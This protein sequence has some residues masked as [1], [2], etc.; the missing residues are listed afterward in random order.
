ML[1]DDL[2]RTGLRGTPFSARMAEVLVKYLILKIAETAIPLGATDSP[3]F[4]TYRRCQQYIEDEWSR[5]STLEQIADECS[6]DPAYLCR[7]F[8]RY[9]HQS[10]YQYLRRRKMMHAAGVL[11]SP[12]RNLKNNSRFKR[13]INPWNPAVEV[14][15]YEEWED[16]YREAMRKVGLPLEK[17]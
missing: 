4:A 11:L 2:I 12:T 1:F 9:D 8:R 3:S 14:H 15:T 17:E 7:L 16:D 6:I 10:P 5:L 13:H